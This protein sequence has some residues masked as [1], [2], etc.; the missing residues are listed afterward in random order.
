MKWVQWPGA[1]PLTHP[2]PQPAT[3]SRSITVSITTARHSRV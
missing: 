2:N 1:Q 3:P